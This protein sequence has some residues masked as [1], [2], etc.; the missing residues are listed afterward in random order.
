MLYDYFVAVDDAMA[1]RTFA[2]RCGDYP[3]LA[4]K[5]ADPFFELL[6]VE[7]ALTGRTVAEVEDDP[8]H[9]PEVAQEGDSDGEACVV[10]LADAFR[11]SLAAAD[12]NVLHAAAVAFIARNESGE[13]E[14]IVAFLRELAVLA[15]GAVAGGH[16]LYCNVVI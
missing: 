15:K 13:L 7:A 10:S 16:R 14:H 1:A 9:C 11:D 12:D 4:V 2:D 8:L 3:E 5:G 6:P